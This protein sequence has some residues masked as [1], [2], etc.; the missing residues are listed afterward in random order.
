MTVSSAVLSVEYEGDGIVTEFDY[1]FPVLLKSHLRVLLTSPAGVETTADSSLYSIES[2]TDNTGTLTYA[3]ADDEPLPDGWFITIIRDQVPYDQELNLTNQNGF[4]ASAIEEELDA[5]AMQIAQLKSRLDRAPVATFRTTA[6]Q[7]LEL[8]EP[9]DGMFLQWNGTTLDNGTIVT[10]SGA[11]TMATP[12][13][14]NALIRLNGTTGLGMQGS[15]VTLSDAGALAGL[16]GAAFTYDSISETTKGLNIT[17]RLGIGVQAQASSR[18]KIDL[19]DT[20]ESTTLVHDESNLNIGMTINIETR[21]NT[22]NNAGRGTQLT[23]DI[24][25]QVVNAGT[26]FYGHLVEVTSRGPNTEGSSVGMNIKHDKFS[27]LSA[28]GADVSTDD[29][30]TVKDQESVSSSTAHE[31]NVGAIGRDSAIVANGIGRRNI[32]HGSVKQ[33]D[34][35][36]PAVVSAI[37]QANPGV[38]TTVRRHRINTT[39]KAFFEGVVGMIQVNGGYANGAGHTVSAIGGLISG[40]IESIEEGVSTVTDFVGDPVL[41]VTISGS[42]PALVDNDAV[43]IEAVDGTEM[44]GSGLDLGDILNDVY[45]IAKGVNIGAKTFE[46]WTIDYPNGYLP[47]DPRDMPE[48]TAGTGTVKAWNTFTI[49]DTSGYTAYS[50]GGEVH[51]LAEVGAYDWYKTRDGEYSTVRYGYIVEDNQSGDKPVSIT[52]AAFMA[53]SNA[54]AAFRADGSPDTC[55]DASNATPRTYQYR[56]AGFNVG[57][58]GIVTTPTVNLDT[59]T[60]TCSGTG[61]TSTVTLSKYGGVLT[62]DAITTASGAS[63]VITVTNTLSTVDRLVFATIVGGTNTRTGVY[64]SSV[65]PGAGSFVITLINTNA[66]AVNGNIKIAFWIVQE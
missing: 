50:S 51:K 5:L 30:L 37:T 20:D 21:S 1:N 47:L 60:A 63:H 23:V 44:N 10:G 55:F 3:D 11:F 41:I 8:P 7:P 64:I 52:T 36:H 32:R 59:G 66:S 16:S 57:L 43:L 27:K 34:V 26:G 22:R 4:D 48:H 40:T 12:F 28:F 65:V 13:T 42:M 35:G 46:I 39:D 56:G 17:N 53:R 14:D 29:F 58:T 49:E 45:W 31:M 15:V 38:V 25:P 54:P 33:M 6:D 24:G 18:L 62:T 2:N 19:Q 61:G 9:E